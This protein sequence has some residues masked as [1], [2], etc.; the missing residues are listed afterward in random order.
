MVVVHTRNMRLRNAFTCPRRYKPW[1]AM[2]LQ[3]GLVVTRNI[4]EG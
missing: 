2:I 3:D 1:V 4:P